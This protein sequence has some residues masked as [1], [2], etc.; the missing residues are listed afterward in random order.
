MKFYGY[1]SDADLPQPLG[2]SEVSFLGSEESLRQIARFLLRCA[3]QI[4]ATQVVEG[5]DLHFHLREYSNFNE[6]ESDLVV[7]PLPK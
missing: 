5:I 6:F 2:L 1:P 7:V 3:D 4:A